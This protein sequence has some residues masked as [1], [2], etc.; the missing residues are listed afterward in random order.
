[1]SRQSSVWGARWVA[2]LESRGPEFTRPLARAR[3]LSGSGHVAELTVA[4]GIATGRV[5]DRAINATAAKQRR[6]RGVDDG[7]DRERSD[8]SL[9]RTQ[10]CG[11][12]WAP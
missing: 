12:G 9:E 6:V 8:V 4:P 10:Y 1:M 5:M 2:A 11:H 3:A 7:L